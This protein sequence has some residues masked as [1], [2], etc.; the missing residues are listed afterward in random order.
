M[1]ETIGISC[2][3]KKKRTAKNET[4]DNENGQCS[5]KPK[6]KKKQRLKYKQ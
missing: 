6:T 2:R 3:L 5:T 4:T 1:S